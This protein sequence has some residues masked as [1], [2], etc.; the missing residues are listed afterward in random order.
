ME[1]SAPVANAAPVDSARLR[2]GIEAGLEK[3]LP[4]IKLTSKV[5][6]TISEEVLRHLN[7]N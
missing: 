3:A 5:I 2:A 6:D 4:S 7:D 1:Q